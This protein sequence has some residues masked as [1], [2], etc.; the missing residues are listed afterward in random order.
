MAGPALHQ[1]CPFRNAVESGLVN[2]EHTIQVGI[3]GG[4]EPLWQYSYESGMRV[5]HIEEFYEVGCREVARERRSMMGTGPV[6]TPFDID[7]IDP[8][9]APGTGTPVVVGMT[10]FQALQ[11]LRGLR[12]LDIIGADIVEVSPLFDN[13]G[14]TSLAGAT[15]MFELLCLAAESPARSPA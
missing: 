11:T 4:T 9:F 12:G 7:C 10:T 2:P 15:L 6:Y 3:R 14:I 5:V 8:A 13:S 1:G